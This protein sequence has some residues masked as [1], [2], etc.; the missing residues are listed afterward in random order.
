MCSAVVRRGAHRFAVGLL[1]GLH[2]RHQVIAL[3]RDSRFA[4]FDHVGRL[5]AHLIAP[6]LQVFFTFISFGP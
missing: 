4:A 6:P 3:A 2:R 5:I 1:A